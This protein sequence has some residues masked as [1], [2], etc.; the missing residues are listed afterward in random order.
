MVLS[1]KHVLA[2]Y[3]VC[4]CETVA[5]FGARIKKYGK[6]IELPGPFPTEREAHVAMLNHLAHMPRQPRPPKPVLSYSPRTVRPVL[7]TRQSCNARFPSTLGDRVH[8]HG[9]TAPDGFTR[10]NSRS[11]RGPAAEYPI[12]RRRRWCCSEWARVGCNS[13]MPRSSGCARIPS[14]W[15]QAVAAENLLAIQD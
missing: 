9:P 7:K 12:T 5:G 10:T 11:P 8:R 15:S 13:S 1:G 2:K 14:P 6:L 3:V 4:L